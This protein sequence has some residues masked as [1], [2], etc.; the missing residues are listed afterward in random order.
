MVLRVGVDARHALDPRVR[1]L[2][3]AGAPLRRLAVQLDAVLV[4]QRLELNERVRS[5][6]KIHYFCR[7]GTNGLIFFLFSSHPLNS[8]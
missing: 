5:R 3:E 2:L 1:P 7:V 6:A 8:T 4:F